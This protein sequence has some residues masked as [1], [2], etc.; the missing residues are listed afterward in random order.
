MKE[1]NL[2]NFDKELKDIKYALDQSAI[3][4]IT[5]EKGIITH[6]NE[7][8]LEISKCSKEDLIGKTHRVINSGY[9]TKEF[10]KEMWQTISSGEKWR[11][12]VC[13]KAKDDTYYWVDTTI[14]PLLDATG[15]P[16]QYV[17][18][19]NDISKQKEME[20]E[21]QKSHEMYKLIAENS[22]DLI[23]VV[24]NDGSFQYISPSFKNMLGYNIH[25]LEHSDLYSIIMR[26]DIAEVQ[27]Y[28][29]YIDLMRDSTI[30]MEVR[31]QDSQGKIIYFEASINPVRNKGE[32]EGQIVFVMRDISARKKADQRIE[33]L[34]DYDQLTNMSN[35]VTFR[36]KISQEVAMAVR[37]ES[38]LAIV[39]LNIDR[40]R[41]VND[42]FGHESG[43]YVLSVVAD[44][45]RTMLPEKD[46]IGR[47]SG[48][49]FGFI[50]KNL[51][52]TQH[53][54]E[55][56]QEVLR[57]LE[58]PIDISGQPY[59][60]SVSMGVAICPEHSTNPSELS[61]MAEKA[62]LNMKANG[63]AGYEVYRSG[64]VQKTLERIL[65]ER[66]LR[67]S[68]KK[69]Q[70]TLDFQPKFNIE[71]ME[72][73]GVESLV[74]WHHPDLGRITP[75]RFIPIAE[76]TKMIVDLGEW[77]LREVC[78]QVKKWENAKFDPVRV[79]VNMSIVQLEEPTIIQSLRTILKEVQV[80]PKYLEIEVT[81][82]AFS[83]RDDIKERIQEIRRMGIV[84]SIDD[85]GTGYSTF[86]YIKE[87][88]ADILKID[89]AFI[90]DIHTNSKSRAIVKAIISLADTVNLRVIAEG[91][92]YEEQ[93][94]IL[95]QDGCKEGQG[96][97]FSRPITA[98]ECEKF[99]KSI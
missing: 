57:Y 31:I 61:M 48:D 33:D 79:A 38:I 97:F 9:H 50:L 75:D 63:G 83:E 8:F 19:R 29:R 1:P 3:V 54:E 13:N 37:N 15:K 71:T 44:R 30:S 32:Y 52:D 87:L 20:I 56:V 78:I 4:A 85:F 34:S 55:V 51:K 91:V 81:E 80:D 46:M 27:R 70:F 43:D 89:M 94:R 22:S 40:L 88:P 39:F 92:E 82:S 45:L 21:I 28:V 35:R 65:L 17:A 98:E 90:R 64:T 67:K 23:A 73:I 5:D 42:S 11:G 62:L 16:Y 18:I 10:F 60:L 84:V 76:E 47:L 66:E 72:L 6:V 2:E 24:S 69:E 58:E 68:I 74:R 7:L 25:Q 59:I 96:F 93:A 26:E 49:E 86:S 77:I 99:M 95:V 12:E 14:V 53:V 41:H 36:K